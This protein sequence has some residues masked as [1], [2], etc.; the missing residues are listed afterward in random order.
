[1][2]AAT[3]AL[4]LS[5]LPAAGEVGELLEGLL[6]R[7]VTAVE[8]ARPV[9]L[10][11]DVRMVATYADDTGAVRGVV[12]L[13]LSL[14]AVLGAALALVPPHRVEA[15]AGEGAVP[16]DLAENTREVL[17]IAASLFNCGEVHLKL[18]EVAV[19]PQPV[20]DATVAFLRRPSR[21]ADCRVD[22]PGYG[23]GVLAVVLD[24]QPA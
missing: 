23:A 11:R 15:A 6:D 24:A 19:A 7:G 20:D 12:L 5:G 8:E 18:R 14:S 9:L 3:P 1:M 21:R 16:A 22:V 13:D 2:T 10:G 4:A 17:N